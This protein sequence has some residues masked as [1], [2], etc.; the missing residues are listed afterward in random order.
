MKA[1]ALAMLSIMSFTHF[2]P[3]IGSLTRQTLD[4]RLG[5]NNRTLLGWLCCTASPFYCHVDKEHYLICFHMFSASFGYLSSVA[6]VM[7]IVY[8]NQDHLPYFL[9]LRKHIKP[10]HPAHVLKTKKN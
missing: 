8:L 3:P 6:L 9:T 2:I 10:S 7:G 5:S 1:I 4:I